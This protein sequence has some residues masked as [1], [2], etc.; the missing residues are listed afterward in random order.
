V[1]GPA[2]IAV[3]DA[4]HT[5]YATNIDAQDAVVVDLGRC[6]VDRHDGCVPVATAIATG[7]GPVGLTVNPLTHIVYVANT[8]DDTLMAFDGARCNAV[9]R[10]RCGAPPRVGAIGRAPWRIA[11][12]AATNTVYVSL[13]GDDGLGHTVSVV[14]G[15]NCCSAKATVNVGSFP[16]G[17]VADSATHT[18]FVANQAHNEE[19]GSISMID[20][21]HCNGRDTSGCGQTP[22]RAPA[23]RGSAGVALDPGT[24]ALYTADSGHSTSTFIDG[25]TC[26][27]LRQF[28][29]GRDPHQVAI[30]FAAFQ[31]VLD[32]THG[33]LYVPSSLDSLVSII[34]TDR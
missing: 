1:G 23:G 18:V 30:G 8:N 13:L 22:P 11:V 5:L 9:D 16:L 21:R 2:R 6:N 10:S 25:A 19:P 32:R 17:I 29:C 3:D 12:D 4:T 24:H 20:T 14:D 33:T 15:R 31:L 7:V 28:S 34:D 26:N 27:A